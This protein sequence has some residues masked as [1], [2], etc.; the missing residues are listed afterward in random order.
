MRYA[1]VL[2][3]G[4]VVYA[5][6]Y[7]LWSVFVLY[8]FVDTLAAHVAAWAVLAGVLVAVTRYSRVNVRRALIYALGW[9]AIVIGGDIL[10]SVPLAGWQIFAEWT[11]WVTYG[12]IVVVPL[13]YALLYRAEAT[14][15][16]HEE[17]PENN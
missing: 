10:L 1:A 17:V 12:L 16:E 15:D 7:A 8:G 6:L 9:A 11:Q 2:G 4:L 3:W 13:M 5:L 14:R